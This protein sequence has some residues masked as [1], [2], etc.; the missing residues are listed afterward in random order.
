M[1]MYF[2]IS[3]SNACIGGSS[4]AASMAST[5]HRADLLFPATLLGIVGYLIGTPLGLLIA[6]KL[7]LE[8]SIAIMFLIAGQEA[9]SKDIIA[10]P[11]I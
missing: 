3:I 6:K 7:H 4:T 10:F 2:Y 1:F 8:K 11:V 9:A 5:I